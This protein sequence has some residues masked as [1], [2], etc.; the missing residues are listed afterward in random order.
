M[1]A[2]W[3]FT[4]A[5]KQKHNIRETTKYNP[6]THNGVD[7]A[8]AD[9]A[10]D[11]P[12]IASQEGELITDTEST[13]NRYTYIRGIDG[14][15]YGNSHCSSF[16]KTS[17]HVIAGEKIAIMGMTGIA[18]G[19]HT[20][21]WIRANYKDDD[22]FVN[23]DT[24]NLQFIDNSYPSD[25]ATVHNAASFVT[26]APL[27]LYP[28]PDQINPYPGIGIPTGTRFDVQTIVNASGKDYFGNNTWIQV[29]VSGK[30]GWI[31]EYYIAYSKADC[32]V[33]EAQLAVA[34][35]KINDAVKIL[36]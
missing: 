1:V 15:G 34:N 5:D 29:T 10:K 7:E 19:I 33:V 26:K 3:P 20:H 9:H 36:Q 17:G 18:T 12:I 21:F 27:S 2:Y 11:I 25:M 35:K 6:P 28:Q 22:S 31:P 14:R 30:T 23:P 4:L 32:S 8:P 24:Q 13:G 16:L